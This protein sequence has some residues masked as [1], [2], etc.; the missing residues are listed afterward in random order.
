VTVET[1]IERLFAGRVPSKRTL[2]EAPMLNWW[3]VRR[4]S[5]G[6]MFL[7]GVFSARRPGLGSTLQATGALL[8]MAHDLTWC[9]CEDGWYRLGCVVA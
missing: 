6:G 9:R 7:L 4:L 2:S 1:D 3:H 5:S 8:W